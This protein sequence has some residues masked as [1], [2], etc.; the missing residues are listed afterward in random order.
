MF[1]RIGLMVEIINGCSINGSNIVIAGSSVKPRP[2]RFCVGEY[3][4]K[5]NIQIDGPLPVKT[6]RCSQQ[7]LQNVV[8]RDLSSFLL[9]SSCP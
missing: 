2:W 4:V 5:S 9:S 7:Y 1:V 8:L 6:D 3:L